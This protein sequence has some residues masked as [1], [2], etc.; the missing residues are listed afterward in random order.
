MRLS[1]TLG[2]VHAD[3]PFVRTRMDSIGGDSWRSAF[4]PSTF[5]REPEAI[6]TFQMKA[7]RLG[8]DPRVGANKCVMCVGQDSFN[9]DVMELR[10]LAANALHLLIELAVVRSL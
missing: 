8:A 10:A 7:A 4:W 1:L 3:V 6:A 2:Y 9:A 5:L